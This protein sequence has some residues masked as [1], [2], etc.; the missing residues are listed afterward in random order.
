MNH[1]I[2]YD[3]TF[4]DPQGMADLLISA[5]VVTPGCDGLYLIQCQERD[6]PTAVNYGADEVTIGMQVWVNNPLPTL[7]ASQ[8]FDRYNPTQH[9]FNLSVT[10]P[11]NATDEV[12]AIFNIHSQVGATVPHTL[13]GGTFSVDRPVFLQITRLGEI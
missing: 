2:H 3:T 10:F 11:L 4:D 7:I 12:Y 5:I 9:I 1:L 13:Q 6:D 8:R